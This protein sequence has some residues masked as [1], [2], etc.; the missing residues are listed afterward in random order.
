[1]HA[2]N[3][4]ASIARQI[5]LTRFLL[6]VVFRGER[7]ESWHAEEHLQGVYQARTEQVSLHRWW[8]ESAPSEHGRLRAGKKPLK[9]RRFKAGAAC[10]SW[11]L[12]VGRW[13]E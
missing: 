1:M 6:V 5:R 2:P 8:A 9:A 3:R 11:G 4:I 12:I 13:V 10:A 7:L